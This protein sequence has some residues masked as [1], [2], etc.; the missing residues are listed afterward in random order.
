MTRDEL[1]KL[2]REIMNVKGKT[3]EQINELIDKLEKNVP[4]PSVTDLIYYD[5]LSAEEI[6]DKALS[7][8][9]FQL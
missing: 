7:Y 6:V 8:R 2:V 3:E 4:H 1:I 5:D 9:P